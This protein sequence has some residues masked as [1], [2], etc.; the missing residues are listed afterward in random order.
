M[1]TGT[2]QPRWVT[3]FAHLQ[4]DAAQPAGFEQLEVAAD[5][6]WRDTLHIFRA[7]RDAQAV[8]LNIG[9]IAV[10]KLC[11]LRMLWPFT[12]W[13]LVSVDILLAR[14]VTPRQRF[15]AFAKKLLLRKV[16]LFVLYFHDLADYERL[17]GIGPGRTAYVPFKSNSWERLPPARELANDG[18]YIFTAGR[19]MRDLHTFVEA[20]RLVPYPAILMHLKGENLD[21]HGTR[22]PIDALP[23]NVRLLEHD[24]NRATW[25]ER[26]RKAKIVVIPIL[27][28][29]I[30]SSGIGTCIDAMAMRKC[31]VITEGQSTHGLIVDEAL[32]VPAQ[33]PVAMADAVRRLWEDEAFR[34][35]MSERARRHAESLAGA[36]RLHRDVARVTA[37][38]LAQ[39]AR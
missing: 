20:M 17:Y 9:S 30:S 13:K 16:D 37:E 3:N 18:E 38:Y 22:V 24:G 23:P 26:M 15:M 7:A 25:I 11:L 27:P 36:E 4:R 5:G 2:I 29:T 35:A 33:N 12:R 31:V 28:A 8:V 39:S 21:A 34:T 19:T 1:T 6:S 32:V 10:L 14:P